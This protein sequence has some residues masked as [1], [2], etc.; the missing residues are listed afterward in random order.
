MPLRAN[1]WVVWA[2]V[3]ALQLGTFL[4]ATLI[5]HK[6]AWELVGPYLATFVAPVPIF[7]LAAS[8]LRKWEALRPS[9]KLL[10]FCWSLSAAILVAWVTGANFY[11]AAEFHL[12][13]PTIDEV[14]FAM[15][16]C[17]LSASISMYYT[18]LPVIVARAVPDH[19]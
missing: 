18:V 17:V 5:L 6:A 2:L 8:F 16:V 11:Y 4:I 9:P 13:D 19:L 7:V 10:A 3:L 12:I 1:K 14:A 15:A